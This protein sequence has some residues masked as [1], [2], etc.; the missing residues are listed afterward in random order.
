MALPL[1][2]TILDCWSIDVLAGACDDR[3][4]ARESWIFAYA[5]TK[6]QISC[7]VTAQLI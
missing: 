3:A 2:M 5:K 1:F 4:A 7:A 6:V